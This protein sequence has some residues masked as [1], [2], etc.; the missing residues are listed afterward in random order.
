MAANDWFSN[1]SG[2]PRSPLIR[3]Q[4]GGSVGGPIKKDKLFFFFDYEGRR[5]TLSN[6]TT[7]T[8]PLD[9]FRSG[10][11]NYFSNYSASTMSVLSSPQAAGLDPL[12][13]RL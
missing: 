11:I 7:R 9:S 13:G 10:T 4:F 5:D 12:G 6:L 2:V 1:N 3:N 8:V